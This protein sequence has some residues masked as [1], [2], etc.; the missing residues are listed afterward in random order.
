MDASRPYHP[1][2]TLPSELAIWVFGSNL[3]GR[4][5]GGAARVAAERFGARDGVAYGAT[6]D[7]YAI[8]TVGR[9]GERLPLEQV[10]EEVAAFITYA[11]LH[12]VSRF[13]V[14]RVGCGIAGFTDADIAPLFREAPANCS[15][16]EAWRAQLG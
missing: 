16:P 5:A 11:R 2:G 9:Y 7:A 6:G 13:F 8:P 4:H 1:D 12:S 3:L 15:L 14:T 10:G